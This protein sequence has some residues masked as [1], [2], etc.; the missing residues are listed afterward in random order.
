MSD[1]TFIAEESLSEKSARS[2]LIDVNLRLFG[3]LPLFLWL[4]P[5]SFVAIVLASALPSF[6]RWFAG[7]TASGESSATVPYLNLPLDFTAEMVALVTGFAILFRVAAWALF[8]TSGMWS[9]L[10]IHRRMVDSLGRTRTT[11][12]DENPSGRLMNRLIRDYD[13]VRSTAIIFV[14]D[15]INAVVEVLS[16]AVI[17]YLA[18]PVA[19]SLILPLLGIFF[20]IQYHRSGMIEH[21]RAFSA[22]GT[23]LVIGRKH[24]LIEG[25][26][27]YLLYGKTGRLL[28]RLSE[29][30]R[31]YIRASALTNQIETWASF[32]MRSTA[33]LFSFG[34]LLF[35]VF[36]LS[37]QKVDATL[38]GVIISALFGITG[39]IG[40]LD[41]ATSLI[42][43][44]APHIRR[45]FDF[46]DLPP[47]EAEEQARTSA[48][49]VTAPAAM[50]KLTHAPRIDFVDYSMSYR[51]DTPVILNDFRL[52]FEPGTKTALIG[53]T[54]SGKTSLFQSL[55]R[56]VYVHAGEIRIDG[57]SIYDYELR[58]L[59]KNFGIVPQ[60]PHLFAGTIRSNLDR[61]GELS[62]ERLEYALSAVGLRMNL[63]LAIQEGGQNLSLGE[64][65]LVCL[66]R[67]IAADKKIILMDEPTSGLDPE[68]DARVSQILRHRLS[69]TTLITIAHRLDSL[70]HYD[71]V[72]EMAFGNIV[73][74]GKPSTILTQP[75]SLE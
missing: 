9:S 66:A 26:E 36:A 71:R 28:E 23:S 27:I 58:S 46:V 11:F 7:K 39:S 1:D 62:T 33:E 70:H 3:S 63:D 50:A 17:A 13:E 2:S 44:S 20:F 64:R 57:R 22:V 29:S 56:M 74:E 10:G 52:T 15:F 5:L 49:P 69:D 40:W 8:E 12:Y 30:F 6:F 45:V 61:V 73:R 59:R 21:S 67:V 60:F 53:R 48:M 18:H 4:L 14:G 41:F 51:K 68:T 65:Q 34:V 55:L 38:A 37:D 42:S 43:R 32:W 19:A 31:E 24:D 25:R 54:G 75:P 35:L 16:V 47:E 72:V